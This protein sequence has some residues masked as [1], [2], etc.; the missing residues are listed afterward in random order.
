MLDELIELY[1]NE[2]DS[3]IRRTMASCLCSLTGYAQEGVLR[4]MYDRE[5]DPEI[6]VEFFAALRELSHGWTAAR[7]R[8]ILTNSMARGT[9]TVS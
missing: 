8:E 2:E 9:S 1:G 4:D 3:T 5:N 7:F 6:K